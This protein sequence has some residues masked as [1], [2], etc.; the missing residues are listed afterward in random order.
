MK[1]K[2]ESGIVSGFIE[3]I[4]SVIT[5]TH[6]PRSNYL[7]RVLASLQSQTLPL[8]QWEYLFIDN[9]SDEPLNETFDLSWHCNARYIRE[10]ELGLTPAR[11]RGIREAKTEI[12]IFVDDDNVLDENYLET[13][14]HISK[15]YPFLGAWGG[16]TIPDFEE[17]PPDW[18]KPYWI[19]L[20][21]R[22][23]EQDQWSN[24]VN[25]YETTPCGAGMCLRQVVAQQYAELVCNDSRRKSLDRR[26]K[27]LT[28]Y[29]DSDMAFTAC[30]MGLGIGRFARLKLKHLMPAERLKEEY[31]LR[32]VESSAYS[33]TLVESYRN[34]FP[35]SK[36]SWSSRVADWYRFWRLS[37]RKRRF[38][39]AR[40]RGINLAL[41]EL[42]Q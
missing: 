18:T 24:L 16:Q 29:G 8:T 14:L 25:Q 15:D 23:F 12:L 38:R 7:N 3:P 11:L 2:K 27:L 4:I 28:S 26:G 22:E 19:V 35:R 1:I 6:N 21:I 10:E 5:C 39:Q 40:L 9:A 30:D 36:S 37:P 20:A 31:L 34:K 42:H 13:A 33:G 41:K 32:L 17:T